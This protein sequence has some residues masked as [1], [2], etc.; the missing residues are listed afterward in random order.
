MGRRSKFIRDVMRKRQ[1]PRDKK[2]HAYPFI[3]WIRSYHN[4]Y[5]AIGK[6]RIARSDVEG[7]KQGSD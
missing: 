2:L 5:E 1:K 3:S 7:L 4:L 6:G